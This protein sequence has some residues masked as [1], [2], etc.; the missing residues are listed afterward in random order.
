MQNCRCGWKNCGGL[1]DCPCHEPTLSKGLK[2]LAILEERKAKFVTLARVAI[3]MGHKTE[4]AA[5]AYVLSCAAGTPSNP[6]FDAEFEQ[7]FPECFRKA[8]SQ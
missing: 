3:A 2:A 5:K 8:Q 4:S 7:T 1:S 6:G